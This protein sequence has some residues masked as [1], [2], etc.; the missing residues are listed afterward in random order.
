MR[1]P[2]CWIGAVV[3]VDV[4]L[5]GRGACVWRWFLF[6]AAAAGQRG[7]VAHADG[8]RGGGICGTITIGLL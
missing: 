7:D 3:R 6:F 2:V 4:R 1:R 8:G 5:Q